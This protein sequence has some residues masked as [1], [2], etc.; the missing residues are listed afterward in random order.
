MSSTSQRSSRRPP[1]T[2]RLPS[3]DQAA[4]PCSKSPLRQLPRLAAVEVDDEEVRPAVAGEADAVE[5]VEDPREAARRPL[6]LV[7]LLVGR[8]AHARDERDA[9]R[10]GRPHD[11]LDALLQVGELARLAALGGDDVEVDAAS[12]RRR[13]GS[14]RRR[15]SCPSGDQRGIASRRSPE[16]NCCG[17]EEPSSGATQI[18]PRYSFDSRSTAVDDERHAR[19]VRRD[20]R[21]AGVDELVDVFRQHPG[22][23]AGLYAKRPVAM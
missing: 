8:V 2:M 9:R 17:S 16:V 20:A 19:A 7:L 3:G 6:L 22:H 21:V 18:A 13:P 14:R 4:P 11:L 12:S 5:L 15:A 10:V 1:N 23:G